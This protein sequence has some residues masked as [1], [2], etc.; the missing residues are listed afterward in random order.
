MKSLLVLA[1]GGASRP[2]AAL[3]SGSRAQERPPIFEK[4][5]KTEG[6]D[7]WDKIEAIRYTRSLQWSTV[8]ASRSWEWETKINERDG[9]RHLDERAIN[10]IND[11]PVY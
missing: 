11:R 6:L 9:I 10:A 5:V 3:I 2:H 8:D 4:V 1:H 7:S